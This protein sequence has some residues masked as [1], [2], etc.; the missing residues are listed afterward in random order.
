MIVVLLVAIVLTAN[1]AAGITATGAAHPAHGDGDA[2]LPA[3]ERRSRG[4]PVSPVR[5]ARP[6]VVVPVLSVSI[7]SSPQCPQ[8]QR[9]AVGRAAPDRGP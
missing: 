5:L 1:G 4:P 7:R 6:T 8:C 2:L 9:C 3:P